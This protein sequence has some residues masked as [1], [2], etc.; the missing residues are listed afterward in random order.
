MFDHNTEMAKANATILRGEIAKLQ[1]EALKLEGETRKQALIKADRLNE[2]IDSLER[3]GKLTAEN[4][5]E[6]ADSV[7]KGFK[8]AWH[9]L[10]EAGGKAGEQIRDGF[11]K[12]N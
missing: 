6:W 4:A 1:G 7:S 8:D 2:Q 3:D 5:S 9:T 10:S 11:N 12:H